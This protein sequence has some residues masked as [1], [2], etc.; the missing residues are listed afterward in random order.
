MKPGDKVIIKQE[1]TMLKLP[2]DPKP[3]K[4]V[5]VKGTQITCQRGG[6]EK[7]K[8]GENKGSKGKATTSQEPQPLSTTSYQRHRLRLRG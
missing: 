4:V 7:E 2:Y 1:K 6:K 8:S 3:Y 5:G